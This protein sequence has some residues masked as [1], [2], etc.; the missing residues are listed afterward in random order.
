[1]SFII[2]LGEPINR[3]SITKAS[4]EAINV[5][6][7]LGLGVKFTVRGIEIFVSP[8]STQSEIID[9]YH[10]AME[11]RIDKEASK[12]PPATTEW[13]SGG[14]TNKKNKV[15]EDIKTYYEENPSE[16]AQA[17]RKVLI[18]IHDNPYDRDMIVSESF[19]ILYETK[20]TGPHYEP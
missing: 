17:L 2:D 19:R 16:A 4:S 10:T 1:M 8:S 12:K 6:K 18:K 9:E 20:S 11:N 7:V 14:L 13:V 15:P 5:S 3:A